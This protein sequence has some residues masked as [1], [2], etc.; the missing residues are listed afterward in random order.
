MTAESMKRIIQEL[1]NTDYK[2]FVTALTSIE[3]S[4]P[5]NS[6]TLNEITEQYMDNDNWTLLN[7]NFYTAAEEKI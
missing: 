4:Q 7:D 2:N 1:M 6:P 5:T 3:L